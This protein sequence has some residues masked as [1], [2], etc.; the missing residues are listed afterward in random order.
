MSD[1]HDEYWRASEN[2][3]LRLQECG[4]CGVIRFPPT[5]YC[6]QCLSDDFQWMRAQGGGKVWSWVR[7]HRS[8]YKDMADRVPYIVALIQLDEGPMMASTVTNEDGGDL[9]CGARVELEFGSARDGKAAPMFRLAQ[10]R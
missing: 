7:F 5:N 6:G 4:S 9:V 8:Y 10:S 2:H 3:E 1:I